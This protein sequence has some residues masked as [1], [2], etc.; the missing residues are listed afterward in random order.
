MTYK[1]TV[2]LYLDTDAN[3]DDLV[4]SVGNPVAAGWYRYTWPLQPEPDGPF[5]T[6]IE[7]ADG[8]AL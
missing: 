3:G 8:I 6:E 4:D 7:A 5:A 2:I 1:Q